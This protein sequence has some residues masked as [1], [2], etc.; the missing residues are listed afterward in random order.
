MH[1]NI[2]LVDDDPS[3]VSMLQIMLE[4]QNYAVANA[5]D[6]HSA[7]EQL[8]SH[9]FDLI[10]T[11]LKM[12]RVSG[13]DLLKEVKAHY[14][15]IEVIMT[16]AYMTVDT[17]IAAMKI[18]AYDYLTKPITDLERT[19]IVIEKAVEKAKI[20]TENRMLK[21][22]L[23]PAGDSFCGIIGKSKPMRQVY[24][25]IRK[26]AMTD[27]SVLIQGESG[28]GKE[29]VARAIHST[30]S[31]KDAPLVPVDCGS[32][33]QDLL[34][35][36]LFGHTR[37]AF[38]GAVC[39]KKGL[40]DEAH[41][42]TL[43]LDEI[44][45]TSLNFQAK[46]LRALQHKEIRKVGATTTLKTDIRLIAASNKDLFQEVKHGRFRQDLFY[47]I[48]IVTVNI[49][50]L[51]ARKDDIPILCDHFLQRFASRFDKP[52]RTIS[53]EAFELFRSYRWP[54]NVREL[55]NVI[56][57]AVILSNSDQIEKCDLP[58]ELIDSGLNS[59]PASLHHLA[60]N[61]AK[62]MFEKNYIIQILKECD[63]NISS[64]AKKAGIARQQFQR[65]IKQFSIDPNILR[66]HPRI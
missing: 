53:A 15:E 21:H 49:P 27:T 28:T 58:P 23:N 11:D 33:P 26:V 9:D 8:K 6:G 29:L 39:E 48:N 61:E 10:I 66:K 60:F 35:S 44:S 65:K 47:R 30:G 4:A 55:E 24:D 18:G 2:L 20:Q 7:L 59:V 32:I 37:G 36:E 63:A 12:P 13:M 50:P 22:Q 52:V 54:G 17:A 46:L 42:G 19:R 43:F 25:L 51:R 40:F 16:T 5:Y 14:P 34:E 56:E 41:G 62:E 31:R 38:T 64:A 1:G 45:S 3:T 57:R